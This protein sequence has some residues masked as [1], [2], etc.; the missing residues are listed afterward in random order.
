MTMKNNNTL[1]VTTPIEVSEDKNQDLV[2]TDELFPGNKNFDVAT[3]IRQN[4]ND[5]TFLLAFVK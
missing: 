3:F 1:K 5:S 4:R 2:A